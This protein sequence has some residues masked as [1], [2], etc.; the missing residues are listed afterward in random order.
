MPEW[1]LKW[2]VSWGFSLVISSLAGRLREDKPLMAALAE[3]RKGGT[4]LQIVR[5]YATVTPEIT[6]DQVVESIERFKRDLT[7]LPFNQL[8]SENQLC[9]MLGQTKI[10]DFD[11]DPSNDQTVAD[12]SAKIVD[13]A[14]DGQ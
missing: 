4:F 14:V 10:P 12:L 3:Y 8:L 1:L 6:D 5:S 7:M 9:V 2:G 13:K 11:D